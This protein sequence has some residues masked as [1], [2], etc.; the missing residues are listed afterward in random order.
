VHPNVYLARKQNILNRLTRPLQGA[1]IFR[2][3][4]VCVSLNM[5]QTMADVPTTPS[6]VHVVGAIGLETV[7]ETSLP[8]MAL[9]DGVKPE[10][11][12]ARPIACIHMPGPIDRTDEDSFKLLANLKLLIAAGTGLYLGCVHA[13][14]DVDWARRRIDAARKFVAEFG[15]ATECAWA[16]ARRQKSSASCSTS[17]VS[18]GGKDPGPRQLTA[19]LCG[20]IKLLLFAMMCGR[21]PRAMHQHGG[22]L[23]R[24]GRS[25]ATTRSVINAVG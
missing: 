12:V 1:M 21:L 11:R 5:E 24:R 22:N 18:H 3:R 4:E 10:R 20:S 13:A 9:A 2:I 15:V 14:D 23:N 6:A 16:A 17:R 8:L 25:R 7:P 19:R